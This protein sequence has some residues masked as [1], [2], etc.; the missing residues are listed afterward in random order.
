[1]AQHRKW[2]LAGAALFV[3]IPLFA[4]VSPAN[5]S[6][7]VSSSRAMSAVTDATPP[8][9]T[10]V[11]GYALGAFTAGTFPAPSDVAPPN[12]SAQGGSIQNPYYTAQGG[13][14]YNQ[15]VAFTPVA[16]RV[17]EPY[18]YGST[19]VA[20]AV[21]MYGN[22][23]TRPNAVPSDVNAGGGNMTY[24]Q[25]TEWAEPSA[26]FEL[27]SGGSTFSVTGGSGPAS[28]SKFNI[29]VINMANCPYLVR[30]AFNIEHYRSTTA[31]IGPN[32][33]DQYSWSSTQAYT[34]RS[35]GDPYDPALAA[36]QQGGAISS[37][38][39]APLLHDSS[40]QCD[41]PPVPV[42]SDNG[43][44][45]FAGWIPSI[46]NNVGPTIAYWTNCLMV[47]AYGWDSGQWVGKAV[48]GAGFARLG[49]PVGSTI[50]SFRY[51]GSCG[52][53]S[54]PAAGK[55]SSMQ[56]NTCAWPSALTGPIKT[57]L[58]WGIT[59]GAGYFILSFIVNT[60]MSLIK[61][62]ELPNPVE[63]GK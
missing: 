9:A 39:C 21:G 47:P 22:A 24:C 41:M 15:S 33:V 49:D 52:V 44:A 14:G 61:V 50:T 28:W 10:A 17:C 4:G 12:C 18:R 25:N 32:I 31:N 3:A 36:C 23:D 54:G 29:V 37:Q 6:E 38:A 11:R 48:A 51:S 1:M 20:W 55:W 56:M 34:P 7:N 63:G 46:V 26:Q 2:A 62:K 59:I 13:Y 45:S 42:F 16:I 35:Y 53:I 27:Y 57:V 40:H 58:G 43:W 30:T 8:S 60:V 19:Q 5:A